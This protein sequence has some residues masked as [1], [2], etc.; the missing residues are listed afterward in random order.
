VKNVLKLKLNT[1]A[2]TQMIFS[3]GEKTVINFWRFFQET[4]E[5]LE[6]IS[7][8]FLSCNSFSS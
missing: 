1:F 5:K 7:L 3:Q 6:N 2:R 4:K 8:M